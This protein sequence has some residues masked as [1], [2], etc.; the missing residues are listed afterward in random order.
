MIA[1]VVGAVLSIVA[2]VLAVPVVVFLVECALGAGWKERRPK[3]ERPAG[4]RAVI[5]IPAHDE[6]GGIK[7]TLES[8][9]PELAPGDTI[10]VI[11][12]NCAD[13]TAEVARG[14]GAEVVERFHETER[15]KGFALAFGAETIAAM[16]SPPNVV[17]VLDADCRFTPGSVNA[18]V[19]DCLVQGFPLQSDNELVCAKDA[20][21]EAKIGTF[22]FRVKNTLRP[23]GLDRLGLPRPLAGTGMAFSW[24]T[25]REAPNTGGWITEDLVLGLELAIRESPV[26]LCSRAKVE[27]EIPPTAQGHGKQRQRWEYGHLSAL[28]EYVPKLSLA[29]LR[30]GRIS[31]LAIAL[32]LSVPPLAL[33]AALVLGMTGV[34]TLSG[35]LGLGWWP[36][37][38][39]GG[40]AVALF[41]AV[42]I[43]WVKVGRDLLSPGDFARIPLYVLGKLPSYTRWFRGKG[44][45]KWVRA[46]R[47]DDDPK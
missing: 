38:V 1:W 46:E 36:G 45:K 31:L 16:A 9:R 40:E 41:L 11:A 13:K 37:M 8:L 29:A 34:S 47:R 24:A 19:A 30:Q 26:Y 42:G 27:S 25:F 4:A 28:R 2:A 20:G 14:L 12:D 3:R 21:T 39:M 44:D 23:R 32:D 6:E 10:L 5:L 33:L 18:L 7:T 43:A 17:I 22:A 15:G 35:L